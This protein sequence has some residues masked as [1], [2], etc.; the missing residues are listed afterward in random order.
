MQPFA[1]S[2]LTSPVCAG[3]A[4]GERHQLRCWYCRARRL[5]HGHICHRTA[6]THNRRRK[7]LDGR[8]LQVWPKF[9]KKVPMKGWDGVTP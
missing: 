6:S 4:D 5:V 1:L 8:T 3:V 9:E 7:Q 2:K